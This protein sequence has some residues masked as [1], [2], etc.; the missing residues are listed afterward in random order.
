[1]GFEPPVL[2]R[3]AAPAG[4][5]H[6]YERREEEHHRLLRS[7]VSFLFAICGALAAVF[8]FF[9]AMGAVDLGDAIAA[10][11]VAIVFA[12][13]WFAG[14]YYRHRTMADRVQWRDRERRGF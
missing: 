7:A 6:A 3:G 12:L 13:V 9:A 1:M 4:G 14:F 8:F 11:I 5:H 2:D 10:T